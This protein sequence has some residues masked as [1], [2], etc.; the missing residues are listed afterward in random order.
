M[1]DG[2]ERHRVRATAELDAMAPPIDV[3]DAEQAQLHAG[4][5][6]QERHDAHQR[7]MRVDVVLGR[8]AA[9]HP[10]LLREG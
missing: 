1:A 10:A 4:R 6:V 2:V 8:P 5:G 9:E 7:L 3:V